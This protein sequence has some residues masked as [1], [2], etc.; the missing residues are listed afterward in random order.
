MKKLQAE[1]Q[2]EEIKTVLGWTLD[3]RHLL[4]SLPESK[5]TAWK[6]NIM[7]MIAHASA[8]TKELDTML[9]QLN[10]VGFII[11]MMRH[12]LNC[13]HKLQSKAEKSK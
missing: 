3:T 5:V 9:G 12:F 7:T 2:M 11:P 8:T 13:L 6:S 1:G 4:I 10:Q